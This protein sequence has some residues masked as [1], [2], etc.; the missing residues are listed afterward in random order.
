MPLTRHERSVSPSCGSNLNTSAPKSANCSVR[1]LPATSRDRSTTRTPFRGPRAEGVKVF[2]AGCLA[3]VLAEELQCP[4]HGLPGGR[5]VV[6]AAL[7][8]ME[9]V[10]GRII[11]DLYAGMELAELVHMR[12]RDVHVL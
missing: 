5:R 11:E 4:G 2:F 3:N 12:H 7:V 8:A 6:A 10:V 1:I 9:A